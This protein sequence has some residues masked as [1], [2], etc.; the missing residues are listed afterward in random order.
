M[1][2]RKLEMQ[3]KVFKVFSDPNRLRIL[4]HLKENEC[5]VSTLCRRLKMKQSTVSQHLRL[6]KDCGA[7]VA[8]RNGREVTYSIRDKK[9][10]E[11]LELS[12]ELLMLMAEDLMKCVCR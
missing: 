2:N 4:E 11:M 9:V 3:A 10:F 8:E 7:V 12:E 6:L 5:N 1:E